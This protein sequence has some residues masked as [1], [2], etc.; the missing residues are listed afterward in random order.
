M[1]VALEAKP[2]QSHVPF[3]T[4]SSAPP[5][6]RDHVG[7]GAKEMSFINHQRQ[8][9]SLRPGPAE[10]RNILYRTWK[11]EAIMM[12]NNLYRRR[13]SWMVSISEY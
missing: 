2:N 9:R 5:R 10:G 13:Q 1:R 7:I 11:R 4:I 3:H 6:P 12:E 8:L